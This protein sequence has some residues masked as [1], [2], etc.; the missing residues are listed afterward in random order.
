MNLI[1]LLYL[2]LINFIDVNALPEGKW[3]ANLT[4]VIL[5]NFEMSILK[6]FFVGC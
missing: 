1:H 3:D 5:G 2:I 6:N 4:K